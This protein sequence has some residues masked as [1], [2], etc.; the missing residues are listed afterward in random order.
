MNDMISW[1]AICGDSADDSSLEVD[2]ADTGADGAGDDQAAAF[3]EIEHMWIGKCGGGCRPAIALVSSRASVRKSG[4]AFRAQV[5]NANPVVVVI[6]NI[7][8]ATV[9]D[10]YMGRVVEPGRVGRDVI[11]VIARNTSAGNGRNT[12][13]LGID[14]AN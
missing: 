8:L 7:Q 13:V 2:P 12:A 5:H 14:D 6:A 3:V 1:Q 9:V 10:L 11:A 4:D